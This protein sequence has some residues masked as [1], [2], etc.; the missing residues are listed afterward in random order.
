MG[1]II[2]ENHA[3]Q[4]R[5]RK[6]REALAVIVFGMLAAIA[7]AWV[8]PTSPASVGA[9]LVVGFLYANAFEYAVHR[10]LLHGRDNFFARRHHLHHSTA[11]TIEEPLYVVII[12][13]PLYAI[14]LLLLNTL[15]FLALEWRWQPGI[16]P[17]VLVAFSTYLVGVEE[18]HW[19]IHLGR[20]PRWMEAARRYHLAHHHHSRQ[21]HNIWLP[22]FDFLLKT[23]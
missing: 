3:V 4:A 12:G 21:K 15:P 7:L 5:G 6:L 11:G 18:I 2:A 9:G 22:L 10:C 16:A 14:L 17:G 13:S 19:R 1:A 23:R 20:L 8:L